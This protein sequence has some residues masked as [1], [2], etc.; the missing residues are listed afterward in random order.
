MAVIGCL[1]PL[2]LTAVGAAIGGLTGGTAAG[3]WGAAVGFVGGIVLMLIG[4]WMF[5]RAKDELRE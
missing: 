3:L 5:Q 4:M 2:A 1:L